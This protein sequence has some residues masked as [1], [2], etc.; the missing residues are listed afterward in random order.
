MIIPDLNILSSTLIDFQ[1]NAKA[2]T[3]NPY[4]QLLSGGALT[5][6]LVAEQINA[7]RDV[8]S[9]LMISTNN[10]IPAVNTLLKHPSNISTIST[11]DYYSVQQLS[12][13][14]NFTSDTNV[15]AVS[16]IAEFPNV[17][18]VNI[19][20]STD[21]TLYFPKIVMYGPY[22]NTVATSDT[23][24]GTTSGVTE[25]FMPENEIVTFQ[26]W[27]NLKYNVNISNV[28]I[29]SAYLLLDNEQAFPSELESLASNQNESTVYV[30]PVRVSNINTTLYPDVQLSYAY[31]YIAGR[32]TNPN[33]QK[34]TQIPSASETTSGT[35]SIDE[36]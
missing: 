11:P 23:T 10:L 30:F 35:T 25:I 15:L 6:Y 22:N 4:Y 13:V 8:V 5:G 2:Q 17:L 16:S 14:C 33:A 3:K 32:N 19:T 29:P 31:R 21:N 7:I 18:Q 27:V 34:Q 24:S 20:G 36:V 28:S 9:A 26:I 12:H 1:F